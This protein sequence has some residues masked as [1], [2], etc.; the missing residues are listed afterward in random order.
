MKCSLLLLWFWLLTAA[1]LGRTLPPPS[2]TTRTPKWLRDE[3]LALSL[4]SMPSGV[5]RVQF[6]FSIGG[7][8]VEWWQEADG[9]Y[10]G[11]L[12][13]WT[14]EVS[15]GQEAPTQRVHRVVHPLDSATVHGLLGLLQTWRMRA[16]PDEADIAGW[17]PTLDGVLYTLE[18]AT[19]AG[20]AVKSYANPASQGTLPEAARV[21]GF[22]R[23]VFNAVQGSTHLAAFIRGIPFQCYFTSNGSS[24]TC[25]IL[26]NAELGAYKRER[27]RY[28]R[29]LK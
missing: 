10:A 7:R 28:R 18:Y 15:P 26:T 4:A 12:V 29:T 24:T 9:G 13:L 1:V 5:H 21:L 8:V 23:Q 17:Q 14:N 2:D 27:N 11:Q 16:L 3:H 20:Y 25:R 19:P 22:E 6:R